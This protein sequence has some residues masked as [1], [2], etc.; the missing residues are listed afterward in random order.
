M[1]G[2]KRQGQVW[3]GSIRLNT[4]PHALAGYRANGAPSNMPAFA[5]AYC[6]KAGDAMV[7]PNE[8]R[9]VTW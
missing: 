7:R 8:K 1:H 5:K 4:D 2:C 9:V 6:C 3:A